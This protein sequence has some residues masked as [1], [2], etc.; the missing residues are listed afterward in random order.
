MEEGIKI[1]LKP[2]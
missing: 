1:Y 2:V